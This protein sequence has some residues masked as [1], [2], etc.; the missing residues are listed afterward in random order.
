MLRFEEFELCEEARELRR[1]GAA[2]PVQPKVFDLLRYLVDHRHRVVADTELIGALWPDAAV[3]PSSLSRALKSL[4]QV[5]GDDGRQQRLVRTFRGRGYRFVAAVEEEALAASGSDPYVGRPALL[6]ALDRALADA[7]G[8]AGSLQLLIGPAGIGKTR[9][10]IELARRARSRGLGVA[11]AHCDPGAGAPPLAPWHRL[12]RGLDGAPSI[13]TDAAGARDGARFS[14]FTRIAERLERAASKSRTLLV[15]DD[16]H[17]ADAGSVA[18][19][20]FL[21]PDLARLPLLLCV[22][23][24]SEEVERSPELGRELSQLARRA[25]VARH[26]FRGLDAAEVARFVA[27]RAGREPPRTAV[28]ALHAATQGNPFFLDEL[29]RG[30]LREAGADLV[31]SEIV[32]RGLGHLLHARVARLTDTTRSVLQTAAVLGEHFEEELL[33]RVAGFEVG[34]ALA[35]AGIEQLVAEAPRGSGQHR[36]AHALFREALLAE[37]SDAA[38]ASLHVRAARALEE[39]IGERR[40]GAEEVAAHWLAA[41]VRGEPARAVEWAHRAGLRALAAQG[42]EQAAELLR[43]ATELCKGGVAPPE[44]E[45]ELWTRLAEARQHLGDRAGAEAAGARASALARQHG[46]P[47]RYAEAVL[48]QVGPLL[49]YRLPEASVSALLLEALEALGPAAA[50]LAARLAARRAAE[51]VLDPDIAL[52]AALR[53]SAVDAALSCGDAE[54]LAEVLMTPY[55]GIWEHVEPGRRLGLADACIER[56]RTQGNPI[57]EGRGRILRLAELLGLG[58][59]DRFDEEVDAVEEMAAEC[60]EPMGRYQVLLHRGTRALAAGA[61]ERSEQTAAGALALG[62][63][64]E[65]PGAF[66]LFVVQLVLVRREQGRLPETA[67]NESL[68]L[69]HPSASARGLL[70]WCFAEVGE[71]EKAR[72]LLA[73]ALERDVPGIASQPTGAANAAVL[74]RTCRLLGV[75]EPAAALAPV[76]APHRRRVV[77][78]GTLGAHGP[79]AWFLAMLADLAGRSGEVRPL[80]EEALALSTRAGALTWQT[81]IEHDLAAWLAEAGDVAAARPLAARAARAAAALGQDGLRPRAEDLARR[82]GAG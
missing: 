41:G 1:C 2:L 38:R 52:A 31:W 15:I 57:A 74:A 45:C 67:S 77:L 46:W 13:P 50:P 59:F 82:L 80:L 55:S 19:L 30:G 37:L 54:V 32:P 28:D 68:F 6:A 66:E 73:E 81:E 69:R 56:A 70:A 62:R 10:A 5:L 39:R 16:L 71:E 22:T 61:F 60:R 25:G 33:A 21:V 78:R 51:H 18:L 75:R 64:L 43:R 20:A 7:A 76:L 9:T 79:G 53:R 29:V 3:T 4:R 65:L 12:L 35:E 58:A 63:R 36:F 40:A 72:R 48:A 8:G 47:A 23:V 14:L 49:Q 24:R 44:A 11:W 34:D 26:A 27:L 17:E 42:W